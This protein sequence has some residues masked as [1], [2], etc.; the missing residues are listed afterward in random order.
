M[1][2]TRASFNSCQEIRNKE[3]N[4]LPKSNEVRQTRRHD[5]QTV[6]QCIAEEKHEELV[7]MEADTVVD[8]GAVVI[9]FED[10]S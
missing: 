6:Q 10:A 2:I 8:P 3:K 7:I 4:Y 9:H 1:H 5:E